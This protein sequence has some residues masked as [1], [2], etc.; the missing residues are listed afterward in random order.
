MPV[1][2]EPSD[3]KVETASPSPPEAPSEKQLAAE[4][5]Q[6]FQR[7]LVELTPKAWVAYAIIF[8]NVA[9][10]A[11]MVAAG[12][13]F[14]E[15]STD[16]LLRFG[17]DYAPRTTGG[18]WWRLITNIFV[19]VGII[20]L[21][22][23]MAV[24]AQIGPVVERLMGNLAFVVVY[25]LAGV[26]GSLASISWNAG[27]VSAGASGAIFGCYGIFLAVLLRDR[28][29][30]PP[31]VRKKL[32]TGAA[33]FIIY[34]LGFAATQSNIDQLAHVGGL[35]GGFLLGLVVALPLTPESRPRRLRR[36][37]IALVVGAALATGIAAA[38]P[39]T[40]DLMVEMRAIEAEEARV[41]KRVQEL[42]AEVKAGKL[43]DAGAAAVIRR[44]I[45]PP[46]QAQ[47]DRMA[48]LAG[49]LRG[50]PREVATGVVRYLDKRAQAWT[51]EAEAAETKNA[52]KQ[53]EA[54]VLFR[55][56]DE[57]AKEIAKKP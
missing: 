43:D 14:M 20:H 22:F 23:N 1:E 7:S 42:N 12:A 57:I 45:L 50:R 44:E 55:G 13:G 36:T 29:A 28:G 41:N 48:G 47:H 5:M 56:A 31:A 19:H 21:A 37:L 4:E 27:I 18:E 34:N 35:A 8:A 15:P 11:V 9:V 53:K 3:S 25:V 32:F 46:V 49:Q 33:V 54:D 6:A 2:P 52:A 17:A 39:R 30:I 10:F 24:L 38:L 40:G 16:A 51:L 26:L